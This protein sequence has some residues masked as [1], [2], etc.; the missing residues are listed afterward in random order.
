[1]STVQPA[2]DVRAELADAPMGRF[3][4]GV[5]VMVLL[6]TAFDGLDT[7][8]PAYVIKFV[9]EPWHL[10][11]AEAGLLVSAGLIGFGIGSLG[12]GV[13]ADR[14]GRKPTL[15]AGLLISGVFSLA[16]ALFADS[17]TSFVTLRL[18]TGLG[19]GVLLPLGTAYCS[20]LM[21]AGVRNRMASLA[22]TG[23]GVGGV[24]AAVVGIAFTRSLGWQILYYLGALGALLG[25]AY[26]WLLPESPE[27]LVAHGRA[28]RAAR[29]LARVNPGRARLYR[30]ATLTSDRPYR[31]RDWRLPLAAE[32]R[33]RTGALWATA[34][35]LLFCIYGL[36]GWTP[37][38]MID[39]GSSF[40]TGFGFGAVLQAMA[41]VGALAGGVVADRLLGG[42]RALMLWCGVGAAA[43]LLV[44]SVSSIGVDL[45]AVGA[46]GFCILGGQFM[47]N[48]V[49]AASYPVQARATGTG[50]MLGVGRVGGILGPYVGGWLLGAFGGTS[51]LFYA[52]A[53]AAA[54]AVL[55]ASF[56]PEPVGQARSAW[57]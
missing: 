26:L 5:V 39:R 42:R 44:A 21:P 3:H 23:F 11:H 32:Y 56:V 20:E 36:A 38:L 55:T 24:L 17:F 47:L 28:D 8:S 31:A 2:V 33:T 16:T 22:G 46:A 19:L 14:F 4:W 51:V 7:F 34:F 50:F 37:S 52:V 41:V 12:H 53:V 15:I 35:L 57:T 1:M 54:L 43:A 29:L 27:Y 40:A 25:V 30:A 45:V 48:N 10:S 18:L 6:A 49:C 9:A 13:V